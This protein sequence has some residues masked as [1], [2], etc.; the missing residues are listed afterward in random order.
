M[1]S[2]A[3]TAHSAPFMAITGAGTDGRVLLIRIEECC[4]NNAA[5]LREKAPPR[6]P[7]CA[8]Q[9]FLDSIAKQRSETSKSINNIKVNKHDEN[10]IVHLCA[11]VQANPIVTDTARIKR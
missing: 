8:M 11:N 7:N 9:R 1:S 2:A 3:A 6:I 4:D 5:G 10:V